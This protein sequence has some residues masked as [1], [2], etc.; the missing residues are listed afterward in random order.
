M[1]AAT[2]AITKSSPEMYYGPRGRL[3][4]ILSEGISP[5]WR[6]IV[7]LKGLRET[8]ERP[9]HGPLELAMGNRS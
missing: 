9:M 8:S 7:Q 3:S 4:R 6:E 5:W 2:R 1:A